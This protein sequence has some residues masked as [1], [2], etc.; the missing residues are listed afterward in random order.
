VVRPDHKIKKTG[1][2]LRFKEIDELQGGLTSSNS[3]GGSAILILS[4]LIRL[5]IFR[6]KVLLW[7]GFGGGVFSL[8]NLGLRKEEEIEKRSD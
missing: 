7:N 3:S 5:S 8:G 6:R 2:R 1:A 4:I